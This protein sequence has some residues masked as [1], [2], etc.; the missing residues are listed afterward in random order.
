VPVGA[1]TTDEPGD[2][3]TDTGTNDDTEAEYADASTDGI[4]DEYY[5][6]ATSVLDR[7]ENTVQLHTHYIERLLE[8]A[9]TPP[10]RIT[11]DDI[12]D[13]LDSEGDVSDF[14]VLSVPAVTL[15]SSTVADTLPERDGSLAAEGGDTTESVPTVACEDR[16]VVAF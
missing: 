11:Q 6:F 3:V 7:S 14:A 10:S 2:T 9:D 13:Y 5:Q 12:T 8:H 15:P 4:L 16:G 1:S